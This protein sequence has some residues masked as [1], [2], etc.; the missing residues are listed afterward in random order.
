MSIMSYKLKFIFVENKAKNFSIA[1]AMVKNFNEVIGKN[2][3]TW[4]D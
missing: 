3:K 4:Y 1:L 2:N